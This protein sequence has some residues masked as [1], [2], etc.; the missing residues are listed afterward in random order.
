MGTQDKLLNLGEAL[1]RERGFGGFSYAD[2]ATAAGIRKASVHHHFP[3]K[4][5]FGLAVLDR[6]SDRLAITLGDILATSRNGAQALTAAIK[7]YRDAL[8]GGERMCLCAALA[9]DGSV[10]TE[11]M[12]AM[13]HRSNRMTCDWIE[14][15]LVSGRR[16][17]SIAVAGDPAEEAVSI[18]AQLQ[19]A[20][21]VAKAAG[22]PIVF[23]KAVSTL[24]ARLH[25]H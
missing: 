20:Q 24:A 19:G 7:L 16:D 22:D 5:D 10:L 15:V 4:A 3:A 13:L 9:A 2:L 18:L 8:D 11:E 25:R 21:L 1:I 17:R 12:R 14:Q 23:D 6:Y